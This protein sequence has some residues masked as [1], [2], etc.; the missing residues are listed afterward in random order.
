MFANAQGKQK[1]RFDSYSARNSVLIILHITF[2]VVACTF[3][4]TKNV[5]INT[6]KFS[7]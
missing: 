4:P 1:S 3:S 7:K 5:R 2:R 6:V